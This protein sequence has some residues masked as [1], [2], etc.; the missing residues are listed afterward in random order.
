MTAAASLLHLLQHEVSMENVG[1][2]RAEAFYELAKLAPARTSALALTASELAWLREFVE[3]AAEGQIQ[4]LHDTMAAR[5]SIK[6]STSQKL[7]RRLRAKEMLPP[8]LPNR[9][10][11][12]RPTPRALR[13]V[14]G[15]SSASSP[16]SGAS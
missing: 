7:A 14:A 1:Q 16:T 10:P 15:S 12:W 5:L 11:D 6:K 9:K 13:T 4:V 2:V 3:L 8:L